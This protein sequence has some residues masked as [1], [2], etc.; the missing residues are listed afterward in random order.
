MRRGVGCDLLH[1][2]VCGGVVGA[3]SGGGFLVWVLRFAERLGGA[4]AGAGAES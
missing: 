4:G 3:L 1:C 2:C